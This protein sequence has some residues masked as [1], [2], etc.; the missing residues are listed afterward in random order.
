MPQTGPLIDLELIVGVCFFGAIALAIWLFN[1][2]RDHARKPEVI[3][4]AAPSP[5]V[6]HREAVCG[7]CRE[8]IVADE[9]RA[10]E[11]VSEHQRQGHAAHLA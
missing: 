3:Y 7:S 4:P 1:K 10:K 6:E 5:S 9:K 11:F 2:G 8:S